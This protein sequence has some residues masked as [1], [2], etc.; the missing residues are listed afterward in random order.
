MEAYLFIL[1]QMLV[2]VGDLI[3]YTQMLYI[4]GFGW[5]WRFEDTRSMLGQYEVQLCA[6]VLGDCLKL[7]R[8]AEGLVLK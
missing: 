7:Y 5:S 8:G 1:V 3:N 2:G 6:H 4:S